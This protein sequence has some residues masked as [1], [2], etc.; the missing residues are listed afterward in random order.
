M[1][2]GG[3]ERQ[4]SLAVL[5]PESGR[6]AG[7]AEALR[8]GILAAHDVTGQGPRP[9][10][11]FYDSSDP[12]SVP[13]LLRQAASDGATLAIGPLQKASVSAL[14]QSGAL[15]IPTL[16]LNRTNAD[17]VTPNLYQF[18]L[19][20]E[21]EA[22]EAANKA[23]SAGRR[24]ALVLQPQGSWGERIS[25]AFRRQWDALGGQVLATGSYSPKAGDYTDAVTG[26]LSGA[27][28][29]AAD[30]LFLVAT[31]ETARRMTPEILSA[32]PGLA[33]YS[34]SHVYGG[35]F[36]PGG[37]RSLVGLNFVDIPWLLSTDP[38]DPLSREQLQIRFSGIEGR[39]TRLYA[40]GIDAYQLAPRLTWMA[41]NPGSYFEGTTGRLS[42]DTRRRVRREL[43]L[44][45]M[46]GTGPVRVTAAERVA[47]PAG[48]GQVA[49][50]LT[51]APRIASLRP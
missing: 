27:G 47:P 43:T 34:T 5:L 21:D 22:A 36:D 1:A 19:S 4:D 26:L 33:V 44:A 20:P 3:F 39:F 38:S 10:I 6:F 29:S 45:R 14:A 24:N 9:Q 49:A 7:P 37:D 18:A 48:A 12:A 17:P 23:W 13:A 50:A 11:R 40:M 30:M 51:G 8:N 28:A 46:D 42:L 41:A 31:A 32:A 35:S 2:V 25:G 16:A 15:P